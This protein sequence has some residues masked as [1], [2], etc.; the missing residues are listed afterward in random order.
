GTYR[1]LQPPALHERD[2]RLGGDHLAEDALRHGG[3]VII[4]VAAQLDI[5]VIRAVPLHIVLIDFADELTEKS[6]DRLP[7]FDIRLAQAAGRQTADV[8][9]GFYERHRMT[10]ARGRDGG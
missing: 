9:L 4:A 10:Q 6:A 2:A 5:F 8:P 7:G 3:L 1:F